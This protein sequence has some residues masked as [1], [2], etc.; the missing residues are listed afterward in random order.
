MGALLRF[1]LITKLRMSK[2]VNDTACPSEALRFGNAKEGAM[3]AIFDY[4]IY[5]ILTQSAN[6]LK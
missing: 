2:R 6:F 5:L 1:V 4:L 3:G